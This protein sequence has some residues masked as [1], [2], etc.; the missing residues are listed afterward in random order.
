MQS[1]SPPLSR[2]LTRILGAST[3]TANVILPILGD[4]ARFGFGSVRKLNFHFSPVSV[5]VRRMSLLLA[6]QMGLGRG[7]AAWARLSVNQDLSLRGTRKG[8]PLTRIG[9]AVVDTMLFRRS[10]GMRGPSWRGW[11]LYG[12]CV[13]ACEP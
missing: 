10:L 13:S 7:A 8:K 1:K 9:T 5:P 4:L 11:E 12:F 2:R 6:L 3:C